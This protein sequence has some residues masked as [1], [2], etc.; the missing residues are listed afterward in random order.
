MRCQVCFY[1]FVGLTMLACNLTRKP[2]EMVVTATPLMLPTAPI[3]S[4]DIPFTSDATYL[5]QDVCFEALLPL[6]GQNFV[7][8]D[9]TEME[10]LLA[11]LNVAEVCDQDFEMP[12]F[13][14]SQQ[15][16]VGAVQIAQGCDAEFV[17]TITRNGQ[18]WQIL[19][20]FEVKLGCDYQLL[21]SYVAAIPAGIE[22][23]VTVD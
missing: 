23:L 13:D 18:Q 15:I 7:W 14:F 8:R 6:A 21:V 16:V 9:E 19:L 11:R 12:V 4:T 5:L 2:S 1:L 17:P 20:Q 3:H 10:R 22:V